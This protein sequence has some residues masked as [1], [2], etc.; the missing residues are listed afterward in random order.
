MKCGGKRGNS[1]EEEGGEDGEGVL[2]GVGRWVGVG[3]RW[4]GVGR[5]C[6]G[7]MGG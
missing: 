1:C 4:V 6:G 5:W 7:R 2:R 3:I